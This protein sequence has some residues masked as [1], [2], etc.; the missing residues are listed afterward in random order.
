MAY[1]R[2]QAGMLASKP[3]QSDV[4]AAQP[5]EDPSVFTISCNFLK[6][7]SPKRNLECGAC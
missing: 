2:S 4:I 5:L 1:L 7:F 3:F 6:E